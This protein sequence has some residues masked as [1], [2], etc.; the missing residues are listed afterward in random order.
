MKKIYI[1]PEI[2][3]ELTLSMQELLAGSPRLN[4]VNEEEEEEEIDDFNKLL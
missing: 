3:E 4:M 1:K 2:V